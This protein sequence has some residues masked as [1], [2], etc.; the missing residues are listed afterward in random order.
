[1]DNE[2]E[3]RQRAAELDNKVTSETLRAIAAFRA[4]QEHH[5]VTGHYPQ[6]A[7]RNLQEVLDN[8]RRVR[9]QQ[10]RLEA[11]MIERKI[12]QPFNTNE[13]PSHLPEDLS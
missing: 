11:D 5:R 13:I 2:R 12:I 9:V 6:N 4:V 1:M 3:L 8:L 10:L 7:A